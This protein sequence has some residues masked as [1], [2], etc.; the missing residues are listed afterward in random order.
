MKSVSLAI[1]HTFTI[2]DNIHLC[3]LY[4]SN[5]NE[6]EVLDDFYKK[7]IDF[8]DRMFESQKGIDPNFRIS[9][10]EIKISK[11]LNAKKLIEAYQKAI[12]DI[13]DSLNEE[14]GSISS[15]IDEIIELTSSTLYKLRME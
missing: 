2:R 15:I 7:V 14:E 8:A 13:R 3:H 11:G 6:H 10:S 1:K 5:L 9:I 12:I 4:T